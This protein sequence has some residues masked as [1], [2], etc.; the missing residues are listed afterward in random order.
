MIVRDRF[1]FDMKG[2]I[3]PV[4]DNHDL[5]RSLRVYVNQVY[6]LCDAILKSLWILFSLGD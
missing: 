4:D 2:R 5:Y 1:S 6:A 3:Y